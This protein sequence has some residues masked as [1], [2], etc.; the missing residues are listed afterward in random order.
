M[1][2]AAPGLGVEPQPVVGVV[3][4]HQQPP[5]RRQHRRGRQPAHHLREG[6]GEGGGRV[7]QDRLTVST[8]S[9]VSTSSGVVTSLPRPVPWAS[10]PAQISQMYLNM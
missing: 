1:T 8:S 6:E 7:T 9:S 2:L 10:Q 5:V 3:P 4:S